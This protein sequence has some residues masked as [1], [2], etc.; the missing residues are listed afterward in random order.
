MSFIS[1]PGAPTTVEGFPVFHSRTTQHKLY[2]IAKRGFD[3][4]MAMAIALLPLVGVFAVAL[5]ILNP[6]YNKG[7]LFFVQKR[8]G[9]HC[10]PFMAI[11]FRTMTASEQ[12]LRTADCPLEQDRITRLGRLLRKMRIDELPQILNVLAGHMSMIGPRPDYYEHAL[13]YLGKVPGYRERH[14]VRPGISGLAQ[15]EIGYVQGYEGTNRKVNADL[16]YIAN[17]GFQ[18]DTWIVWRTLSVIFNRAG[19]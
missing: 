11:K 8:M 14:V 3:L 18:L 6:F 13:Q 4:A 5:L 2:P 7:R 1:L 12:I 16:Y 10:Q 19:S 17:T 9:Q 15:T